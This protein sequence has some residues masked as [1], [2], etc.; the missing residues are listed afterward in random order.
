MAAVHLHI[1]G[2][3]ER[4]RL[5]SLELIDRPY[6]FVRCHRNRRGPYT[7]VD[8]FLRKLLIEAIWHRPELVEEYRLVLLHGMPELS[9]I[10][11]EALPDL[12]ASSDFAERTRFYGASMIR[13][14]SQ[15]IVTFIQ[16]Y[17]AGLRAA[18]RPPATVVFDGVHEAAATTQEFLALLIRWVPAEQ[19]RVIVGSTGAI[20]EKLS[21]ELDRHTVL[22]TVPSLAPAP[23]APAVELVSRYLASDGTD[24]DPA[25]L[26]AY[27]ALD[28]DKRAAY[29]DRHADMIEAVATWS[30]RVGALAYHRERGSDP[31]GAGALALAHATQLCTEAGFSELVVELG[32]RG[33]AI[34]DADRDEVTFRKLTIQIS[35]A[36]IPCGRIDEAIELLHDVRLRYCTP[37]VHMMTSYSLAM[38]HT[39]FLVPRDHEKAVEWQNSAI[40]IASILPDEQD[41]LMFTGFQ[42]NAMALI[43]MHRGEL[44]RALTLV[45]GA[46]HRADT[47]MDADAFLLHRSQ[48]LYNRARLLSAMGRKNEAYQVFTMLSEL[49]PHYTDY[50]SERAK[51][52]RKR[53]DL[54]LALADYDRAVRQGPPFP[55]LFYNRGSAR[56]EDGDLVGARA[57][58]DLVLDMEPDDVETRV[59]R[60]EL[61]LAEDRLTEA[62]A[63]IE[64]GLAMRP[65]DARL[66]CLRGALRLAEDRLGAAIEDF[67]RA[68]A[69]D[70]TYPAALANRAVALF[71]SGRATAAADD[72][73][74]ALA[75][76]GDDPDLLLNRGLAHA[77]AGNR[78]AALADFGRALELPDADTAELYYQRG[79]CRLGTGDVEAALS[80]LELA[81]SGANAERAEE[82]DALLAGSPVVAG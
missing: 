47:R 3:V 2:N 44:E 30:L 12:A 25:A 16:R 79:A 77:A 74:R 1:V 26:I 49:D 48:L 82:I 27:E 55:E 60:A 51:I 42:D 78:L 57:D 66:L 32:Y 4:D 15:G 75:V 17:T 18:G 46:L 56:M 34:T 72:L 9:E 7:G 29:H 64:A 14:M 36:L 62:S 35:S 19:L 28:P 37:H 22:R 45:E 5:A 71:R 63:D 39:R 69:V 10:I 67:D 52:S 20:G 13:C 54:D 73:S 61:E 6:L 59:I 81:R 23:A 8:T 70:A 50:L 41:R 38:M 43:Q 58:F 65:D 21:T 53:G 76:T 80:D 40:A 31:S 24:D 11:G 68:L 33:R